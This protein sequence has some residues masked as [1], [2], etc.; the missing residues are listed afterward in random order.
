MRL[1]MKVS[2]SLSWYLFLWQTVPYHIFLSIPAQLHITVAWSAKNQPLILLGELQTDR[3]CIYLFKEVKLS[4]TVSIV[5]RS[6]QTC[7]CHTSS[8]MPAVCN[9]HLW[10]LCFTLDCMFFGIQIFFVTVLIKHY[11][12]HLW[13]VLSIQQ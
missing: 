12:W 2:F 11:R 13:A 6:I 3:D 8:F 4:H 5:H 10:S 1:Y 7:F 9:N